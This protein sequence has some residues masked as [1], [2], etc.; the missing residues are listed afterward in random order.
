[1]WE[2]KKTKIEEKY[3]GLIKAKLE[4]ILKSR[5]AEKPFYLEITASTGFSPKFKQA[6]HNNREI[7]FSFL[8]KNLILLGL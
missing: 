5:L 7:I 4:G 3:Y 2:K 6:V 1:M 8:T